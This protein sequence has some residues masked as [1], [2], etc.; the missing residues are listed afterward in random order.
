MA[1]GWVMVGSGLRGLM[2]WTPAPAMANAIVS[3]VGAASPAAHSPAETPDTVSVLAAMI[4]SRSV[5][6]PSSAI[7]SAVLLTVIVLASAA[8]A[9][10]R[11]KAKDAPMTSER[12]RRI[13]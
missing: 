4:A 1:T 13:V 6:A 9:I 3:T 8:L 11:L 5:Q 2:V 12:D 10:K 7:V